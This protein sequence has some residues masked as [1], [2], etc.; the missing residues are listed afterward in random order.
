MGR[1][2]ERTRRSG[3][4]RT[5]AAARASTA[6]HRC[7]PSRSRAAT[8]ARPSCA[9]RPTGTSRTPCRS[10]G[11]CSRPTV[12]WSSW[13]PTVPPSAASAIASRSTRRSRIWSPTW[14]SCS[15][16]YDGLVRPFRLGPYDVFRQLGRGGMGVVWEARLR[17]SD[18]LVALKVLTAA[19]A[20]DPA[21]VALFENEARSVAA[22]DHP[23]IVTILDYGRVP[24]ADADGAGLPAG[25][26]FLAMEVAIGGTL[27]DPGPVDRSWDGVRA[28][29]LALLSALGHAH[30]RGVVHRDLKPANV[31]LDSTRTEPR[32]TDFGLAHLGVAT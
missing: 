29:L 22:L 8:R 32:L 16:P 12:A 24:D 31:L 3:G 25:T 20:A 27:S 30:A 2:A 28:L 17:A 11:W 15:R 14:R 21:F 26:P 9:R 19:G 18:E 6:R 5:R 1:P 7:S 10:C 13:P 4:P 23:N